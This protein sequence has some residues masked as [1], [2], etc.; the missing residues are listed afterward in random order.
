MEEIKGLYRHVFHADKRI[1]EGRMDRVLRCVFAVLFI[2]VIMISRH[3]IVG[4]SMYPTYHNGQ[5][6]IARKAIL[7]LSRNE[8]VIAISPVEKLF[9]KRLAGMP[10]DTVT[11]DPEGKIFINDKP[12]GYGEGNALHAIYGDVMKDTPDGGKTITL[13]KNEYFLIGDNLE[14][15]ADSRYYGVFHRWQIIEVIMTV[16]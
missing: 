5:N 12:Y 2:F 3:P 15:S 7:P 8:V 10:G 9:I 13:G 11:I 6:A 16:I 1:D 14:G 4:S